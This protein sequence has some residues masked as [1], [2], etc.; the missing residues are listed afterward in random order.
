ME[1]LSDYNGVWE[2]DRDEEMAL[3]LK[4]DPKLPEF[5]LEVKRYEQLEVEIMNL[6]EFYDVGPIAIYTGGFFISVFQVCVPHAYN[7]W[8]FSASVNV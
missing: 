4:E 5:E 3:L 1:K 7:E 6:P 2:K 8:R